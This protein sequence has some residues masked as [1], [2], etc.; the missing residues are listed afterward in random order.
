M[1]GMH[2]QVE[3]TAWKPSAA[4]QKEAEEF[5]PTNEPEGLLQVSPSVCCAV[6]CAH[7]EN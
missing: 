3:P 4:E 6:R 5:A 1:T 2:A 7:R